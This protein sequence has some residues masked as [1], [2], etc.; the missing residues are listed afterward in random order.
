M[1]VSYGRRAYSDKLCPLPILCLWLFLAVFPFLSL[2]CACVCMCVCVCVSVSLNLCVSVSWTPRSLFR[3]FSLRTWRSSSSRRCVDVVT[4]PSAAW[5]FSS[6]SMLS[7]VVALGAG[8]GRGRPVI[9]YVRRIAFVAPA[10]PAA[11]AAVA[12]GSVRVLPPRRPGLK[13]RVLLRVLPPRCRSGLSDDVRAAHFPISLTSDFAI[14]DVR[15]PWSVVPNDV[16]AHA[17]GRRPMV[18]EEEEEEGGRRRGWE[19]ERAST[20]DGGRRRG[21]D[22]ERASKAARGEKSRTCD[23]PRAFAFQ[24]CFPLRARAGEAPRNDEAKP[25]T[26][27][28]PPSLC[29]CDKAWFDPR[30]RLSEASDASDARAAAR[31]AVRSADC[32]FEADATAEVEAEAEAAKEAAV[33]GAAALGAVLAC[34]RAPARRRLA[35]TWPLLASCMIWGV[36]GELKAPAFIARPR[37]GCTL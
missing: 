6:S 17:L 10:A 25:A 27:G 12:F 28:H 35:E 14:D 2:V 16:V 33:G 4:F 36:E 21:W 34:I 31:E 30:L 3:C 7:A 8:F 5:I 23:P 22:E 26:A 24:D 13:L 1:G 20:E 15:D 19:E 32:E 11:P 37:P 18:E 29:R 9:E